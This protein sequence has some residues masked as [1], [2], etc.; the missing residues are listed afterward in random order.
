MSEAAEPQFD[1]AEFENAATECAACNQKLAGFYYE[2]NGAIVC[3]ACRYRIEA[4]L[5]AGSPGGRAMRAF[6]AGF[7]AAV[8]GA[9]LYYAIAAISGYEFGLIAIVVGWAVGSAVRWGSNGRG[10]KPY[11]ALAIALT[12]FA[13][14]ATYIPPIIQGLRNVQAAE[15]AAAEPG[16]GGPDAATQASA[17]P[18]SATPAEAAP[19]TAVPSGEAPTAGEVVFAVVILLAF[20]SA[21]PFLAGFQNIIGLV[22]IGIGVYEAWK[23]NKRAELNFT[24]PHTLKTVATT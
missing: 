22:I 4:S 10:G 19:T 14:V 2:A 5:E 17:V 23:L 18:T 13:I 15:A 21:A 9:L 24:G 20:A 6:G 3:E 16:A 8:A 7:A 11:Q 1:R 12:Y